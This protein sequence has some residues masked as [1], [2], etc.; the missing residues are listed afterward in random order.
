MVELQFRPSQGVTNVHLSNVHFVLREIS[1]LLDPF[2]GLV[3]ARST[4]LSKEAIERMGGE[5]RHGR[6]R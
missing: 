3:I 1:A 4:S 6:E 5:R 2:L